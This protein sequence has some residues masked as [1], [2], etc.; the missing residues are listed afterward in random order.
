M[1]IY[2]QISYFTYIKNQLNNTVVVIEC[3]FVNGE[4]S[5]EE[6][7]VRITHLCL[8]IGM[9]ILCYSEQPQI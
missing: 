9:I 5:Q 7:V 8:I 2:S 1:Y 6:Q 4:Q 3:R